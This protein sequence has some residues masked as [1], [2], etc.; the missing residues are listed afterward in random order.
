MRYETYDSKKMKMEMK[1]AIGCTVSSI[2]LNL[3]KCVMDSDENL[4]I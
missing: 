1:W 3:W 2:K 4:K